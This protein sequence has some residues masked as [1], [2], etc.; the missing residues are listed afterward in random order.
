MEVIYHRSHVADKYTTT[1]NEKK[2][3]TQKM[4][5]KNNENQK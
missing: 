2:L 1:K 3:N 5:E 4:Q